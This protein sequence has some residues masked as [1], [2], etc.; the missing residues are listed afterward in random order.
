MA[1]SDPL[2]SCHF[3]SFIMVR[4][5]P[6]KSILSALTMAVSGSNPM[7]ARLVILFPHP[8]SPTTPRVS[9]SSSSKERF[10]MAPKIPLL[11]SN[12][13][14]KFSTF[15]IMITSSTLDQEHLLNHHQKD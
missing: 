5:L 13:I 15:R 12:E 10:L 4:S 1:I 2:I 11:V 6:S 14:F 9:P 7:R 3:F 8:D